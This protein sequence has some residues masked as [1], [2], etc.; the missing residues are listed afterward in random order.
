MWPLLQRFKEP[1]IVATLLIWPLISFL[2]SGHRGREPN[3]VDRA[4]LWLASPIQGSLTWLVQ[5][6]SAGVTGYVALRGAH[7]EAGECRVELAQTQAELNAIREAKAE[8]ERLKAALGYVEGT[9]DQEIVARVVGLNPAAQFQSVRLNRG[10]ED[11]VRVGM[12]VTTPNGVLGQVVRS[13]GH[14]SD[15]MLLTDPASRIGAVLQRT[16]VRATVM[17]TGNPKRLDVDYVRLEDDVVEGDALVTSGTD[18]IFPPGLLV[19][20]IDSVSR[21]QVGMFLHASLVPAVDLQRV[22]EVLIIP[23]TLA[24]GGGP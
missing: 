5:T 17:G 23:V 13:V 20:R 18:G 15:V 6:S 19:G 1:L 4:L 10:E 7:E 8:N 21:P 24:L 3:M 14:S 9:V 16:R 12:P 11:G 22:E 2:S